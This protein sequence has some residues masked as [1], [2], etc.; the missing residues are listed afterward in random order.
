[1]NADKVRTNIR[2]VRTMVKVGAAVMTVMGAVHC[3]L[4][5]AEVDHFWIHLVWCGMG[6]ALGICLNRMFCLCRAHLWSVV[7]N[8]AILVLMTMESRMGWMQEKALTGCLAVI[9]L[10]IASILLWKAKKNC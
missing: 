6:L 10:I 5:Y 7:Y 9:G 2:V 4:L 8:T 3:A 1:M